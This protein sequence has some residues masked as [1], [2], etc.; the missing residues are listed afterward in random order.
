[1]PMQLKKACLGV[2]LLLSMLLGSCADAD[3]FQK[4]ARATPAERG[5]QAPAGPDSAWVVAGRHYDRNSLF[6]LLWG[7]HNRNLWATPVKL[8]VFRLHQ[9]KGGLRVEEKGGGFQTTSFHLLDAEGRAYTF[10][11]LDKDPAEV[12][13]AFW[14]RTFVTNVLRDQT[15]AANPFG[16]LVVPVLAEAAGVRH[17]NPA[18]YYVSATDT[19]FGEYAPLVQG[20]LFLLEEKYKSPA[21]L[22][23]AFAPATDF[24]D[25]EEALRLRFNTNTHH[26]DQQAFARARLLDVLLGDWDRHKGQW[27]W[28]VVQQ[29]TDTMYE[30]IPVDRDQ[31]F[32]QMHD[33]LIP[34]IATSK[35]LARKL[36]SFGPEV[37]DVAAYMINARFIDDRLLNELQ[38][39]DWIAISRQLQV[40]LT[41]AVLA[42]ALHQLPPPIYTLIGPQLLENLQKRRDALVEVAA[43]MYALLAEE[44]TIPGSD[45]EEIFHIRRLSNDRTEV[46]VRRK[47]TDQRPNA[48]LYHRIFK[49]NETRQ[50]T[51]HGLAGDDE[52]VIEGQVDN[53][54]PLA[55]YGGLGEDKIIDRSSVAGW[56]KMTSVYDT[57]RGTEIIPGPETRVLTTR[58]VRVHAYDREGN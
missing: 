44:V 45:Q 31:V 26:F 37:D 6:R 12:V 14:R 11:S 8:P 5:G 35:L 38:E 54:I 49:G 41:D 50:L 33:G 30:P 15:S 47:A 40:Q 1:M 55:V 27:N 9:V 56:K 10:R 32:F 7:N 18:L 46:T 2:L 23:P 52:F 43:T 22:T 51:L 42:K 13:S 3:F 20:K 57:E 28:A 58:D 36:H 34:V 19:S 39:R 21:D 24:A 16:A 4:D 25:S 29:G 48:Q 17:T 53:A